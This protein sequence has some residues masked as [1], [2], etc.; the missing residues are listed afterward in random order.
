M[1]S[2]APMSAG[3]KQVAAN[4][5]MTVISTLAESNMYS[6]PV[7]SGSGG[8]A[9]VASPGALGA[10]VYAAVGKSAGNTL[11][12]MG[13]VVV[14]SGRVFRKFKAMAVAGS[15]LGD[16]AT[17]DSNFGTFY[18]EVAADGGDVPDV[19]KSILARSF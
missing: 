17:P 18:L 10:G 3:F 15:G 7:K 1:P 2:V 8:A 4:G 16:V 12:D 11:K 5:Y 13:T 14:S 19:K 6:A 9:T